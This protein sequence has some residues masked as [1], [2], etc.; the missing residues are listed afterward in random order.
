MRITKP[1]TAVLVTKL[2]MSCIRLMEV[3]SGVLQWILLRLNAL[4]NGSE[5]I[6][7]SGP[8]GALAF[9]VDAVVECR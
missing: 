1:E 3:T 6:I 4:R 2:A 9:D 8:R 7:G 5:N